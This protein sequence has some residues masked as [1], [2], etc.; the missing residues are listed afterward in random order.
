MGTKTMTENVGEDK[1][2]RS[3][4][5]SPKPSGL[6]HISSPSGSQGHKKSPPPVPAL[7]TSISALSRVRSVHS[8]KFCYK[9]FYSLSNMLRHVKKSCTMRGGQELIQVKAVVKEEVSSAEHVG[10]FV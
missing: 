8:C 7:S 2:M 4:L 3:K 10:K 9:M 1:S 5:K 6:P